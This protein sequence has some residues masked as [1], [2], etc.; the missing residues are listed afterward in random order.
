MPGVNKSSQEKYKVALD[1][2]AAG[3]SDVNGNAIDHSQF[4]GVVFLAKFGA[5]DAGAVTSIKAQSSEDGS[6]GWAD[7]EGTQVDVADTD[8]GKIAVLELYRPTPDKPF[9]RLV[10]QRGTA[11]ATLESAEAILYGPRKAGVTQ[12]SDVAA[13]EVHAGA[14]EGTA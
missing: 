6:T 4:E 7:L 12:D 11:D 3:Q 2:Q 13:S 14:D 8:D 5:I 1:A 9:V 10:L